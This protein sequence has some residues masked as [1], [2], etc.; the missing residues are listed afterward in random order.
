MIKKNDINLKIKENKLASG[1]DSPR[2]MITYK[3][4]APEE[5]NRKNSFEIISALKGNNDVLIEFNSSLLILNASSSE[6]CA[7]NFMKA[8]KTMNL[9]YRYRKSAPLGKKSFLSQLLNGGSKDAHEMLVYIPDELWKQEGFYSILPTGGLR[10]Y[11][12]NGPT[13]E[14]KILEDVFNGHLMG[15]EKIDFF[16]LVIFDCSAMGQMGIV[17]NHISFD[18]LKETLGV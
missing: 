16:N 18:E 13:D 5:E 4:K 8:V 17:S 10:Y 2:Y 6:S 1:L 9:S 14:N 3:V 12:S 15:E 11:I 7:S